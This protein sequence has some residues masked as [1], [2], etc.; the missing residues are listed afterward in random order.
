MTKVSYL[1][2][3]ND[4]VRTVRKHEVGL[5]RLENS[6]EITFQGNLHKGDPLLIVEAVQRAF[7]L[8]PLVSLP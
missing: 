5:A 2:N 8:T 1:R 7:T 3:S 4:E 6:N